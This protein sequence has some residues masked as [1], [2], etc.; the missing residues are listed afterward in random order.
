MENK[1]TRIFCLFSEKQPFGLFDNLSEQLYNLGYLVEGSSYMTDDGYQKKTWDAKVLERCAG[2]VIL[3][4]E[5]SVNSLLIPEE[6]DELKNILDN[7]AKFVIPLLYSDSS[8]NSILLTN[9]PTSYTDIEI[10]EFD[11][12]NIDKTA[13]LIDKRI[14]G[15]KPQAILPKPSSVFPLS[16]DLKSKGQKVKELHD[17]LKKFPYHISSRSYNSSVF[18]ST[19]DKAIKNFQGRLGIEQTGIVDEK[20]FNEIISFKLPS[21]GEKI[22]TSTGWW[23]IKIDDLDWDVNNLS[24]GKVEPFHT[25]DRNNNKRP[26]YNAYLSIKKGDKILGYSYGK[27]D[28]FICFFEVTQSVHYDSKLGEIISLKITGLIK[29]PFQS[30]DLK[31]NL[32]PIPHKELSEYTEQRLFS[33]SEKDYE[34]IQTSRPYKAGKSYWFLKLHRDWNIE[35]LEM[36]AKKWFN[37]YNP[38]L[39]RKRPEYNLFFNVKK[40]D[41]IIGFYHAPHDEVV[42]EFTVTKEAVT[43]TIKNEKI[44]FSLTRKF[45][46]RIP[47]VNFKGSFSQKEESINSDYYRLFSITEQDYK[48]ITDAY[49]PHIQSNSHWLLKINYENWDVADFKVGMHKIFYAIY[50]NG[51]E[52][53]DYQL[54]HSLK[55]GELMLG[56][57]Y[58]LKNAA[59]CVFKVTA[60]L[61]QQEQK[62]SVNFIIDK[63]LSPHVPLKEFEDKISGSVTFEN[64]PV[65][66]LFRIT[67]EDFNLIV[68]PPP[69]SA[70]SPPEQN[71]FSHWVLKTNIS[72][73]DEQDEDMTSQ[74]WFLNFR[75]KN[76]FVYSFFLRKIKSLDKILTIEEGT[77]YYFIRAFGVKGNSETKEQV[78]KPSIYLSN[79]ARISIEDFRETDF[80]KKYSGKKEEVCKISFEDFLL[81][82]NEINE[83]FRDTDLQYP[84][85]TGDVVVTSVNAEG[86]HSKTQDKLGFKHDILS[87]ANVISMKDVN[88]PLAIG[89]FGNWGTGKSFFMEKLCVK[90]DEFSITA[91]KE[92]EINKEEYEKAKEADINAAKPAESKYVE[93]IVQVKF[94]S[95]HYSDAN[96]WASLITEIFDSLKKFSLKEHKKTE[97]E[98]LEIAMQTAGKQREAEIKMNEQF[99]KLTRKREIEKDKLEKETGIKY[100]KEILKNFFTKEN[101][102]DLDNNIVAIVKSKTEL[103]GYIKKIKNS[104]KIIYVGR[105]ILSLFTWQV[106]LAAFIVFLLSLVLFVFSNTANIDFLNL[107]SSLGWRE[108]F[109]WITSWY[110][111]LIIFVSKVMWG[112]ATAFKN[113]NNAKE[114]LEN[115]MKTI[116][117]NPEDEELKKFKSDLESST[118]AI[119]ILDKKI[120]GIEQELIDIESG[121]KLFDFID[122]KSKDTNYTQQLGVIS[123]IRKDFSRL[124]ELLRMQYELSSDEK[125]KFQNPYEVHLKIDRI[126]LYIDDLDRCPQ[127]IVVKVLEAIHLL[128][129]FP[130]FIVVVGVDPRWLDNSL[131]D[132]FKVQ[133]GNEVTSY[134]YLEKIFQIPFALKPITPEGKK[135]LIDYLLKKEMEKVETE[136]KEQEKSDAETKQE[137]KQK[138]QDKDITDAPDD[139]KETIPANIHAEVST[140][141]DVIGGDAEDENNYDNTESAY[142][143]SDFQTT[144]THSDEEK[145]SNE[146]ISK[147]EEKKEREIKP[148]TEKVSS[149]EEIKQQN[150]NIE[151]D[152]DE[153]IEPEV[154]Q[155]IMKNV[156]FT[157]KELAFMQEISSVFGHS[158]RTINRYINIYR[159]IKSHKGFK[160]TERYSEDDFIPAMILL[161]IVV[162]CLENSHDFIEKI[163]KLDKT[164]DDINFLEFLEKTDLPIIVKEN[165]KM[166]L[167]GRIN[168]KMKDFKRNRELISRFSF[169]TV[170]KKASENS[171]SYRV[172]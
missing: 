40:D 131:K 155:A 124:D 12:T 168:L 172:D 3:F 115:V 16:R 8:K 136:E 45:H 141:K 88:P 167:S 118:A 17:A 116:D 89:L 132:K 154:M 1:K 83:K 130:L 65:N 72:S 28:G 11:Q 24:I 20:L 85:K 158:P 69:P 81:H 153:E 139:T 129:A 108:Y 32:F 58:G 144:R 43:D 98:K 171:L 90:V 62:R 39:K 145:I 59:V 142:E 26:E 149:S 106:A 111:A 103:E 47:F 7:E 14:S 137:I 134:D 135:S 60:E 57:A 95:W 23:L 150:E 166:C 15:Y 93:N 91:K 94:N 21:A 10:L 82:I 70:P 38:V 101:V 30:S 102:K 54:F 44:E 6:F 77:D 97:V 2:V 34:L 53:P 73:W 4:D 169:R 19:T 50:D 126:I 18:G 151:E 140:N 27:T 87:L 79:C 42:C 92:N 107:F 120:A 156:S 109:K 37:T 36:G 122:S 74:E 96:L 52:R 164:S 138:T 76:E 165:I 159:I 31:E 5:E 110:S 114:K 113:I 68:N 29:P 123:W 105:Q 162:G 84:E 13:H 63:I 61:N 170:K 119:S 125:M 128:L 25:H 152:K 35:N 112:V 41:I 121:K 56:Y 75:K 86:N 147:S 46:P 78:K 100:A 64:P 148:M 117:I 22:I 9:L 55:N 48:L 104:N 71:E 49:V 99:K 143:E 146:S 161:A 33:I 66:S 80:H 157:K 163:E 133:F 67:E 51:N 127:D 160:K